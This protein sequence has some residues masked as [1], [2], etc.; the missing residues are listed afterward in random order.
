MPNGFEGEFPIETVEER[1]N[2]EVKHPVRAPAA[3]AGL[4]YGID[5]RLAGSVAVGVG[6]EYRLQDR[7]QI[8]PNDLLGDAVGDRRN[9]QRTRAPI[10]L[11]NIDAAYRRR[12]VAP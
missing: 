1:L 7:L 11:R 10:R 6:M 8:T 12:K 3:L 5:G 4:G 2:V 9:A